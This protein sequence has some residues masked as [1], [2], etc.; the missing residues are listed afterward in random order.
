MHC[1]IHI[2]EVSARKQ[3]DVRAKGEGDADS[4]EACDHNLLSPHTTL[5]SIVATDSVKEHAKDLNDATRQSAHSIAS[6]EANAE[7]LARL[8]RHWS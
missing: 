1:S 6:N 7:L 5:L 4:G 2:S 3:L 8:S